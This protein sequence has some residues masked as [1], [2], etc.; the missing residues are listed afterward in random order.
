MVLSVMI[1]RSSNCFFSS[2]V[3]QRKEFHTAKTLRTPR[4]CNVAKIVAPWR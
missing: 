2:F 4:L 1:T 3:I